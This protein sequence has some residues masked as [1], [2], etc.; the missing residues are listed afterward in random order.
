[1]L[2]AARPRHAA[3]LKTH[4]GQNWQPFE[5]GQV[6]MN[7]ASGVIGAVAANVTF[8]AVD[9]APECVVALARSRRKNSRDIFHAEPRG[10]IPDVDPDARRKLTRRHVI[11]IGRIVPPDLNVSRWIAV[12]RSESIHL[13]KTG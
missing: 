2:G 6:D 5:F 10:R 7:F 3:Q 11:G 13:L 1:M 8:V 9:L 4:R 12:T